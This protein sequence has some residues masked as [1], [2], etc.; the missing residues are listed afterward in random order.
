ATPPNRVVTDIKVDPANHSRV[1]VSFGGYNLNSL[2]MTED[3]GATWQTVSGTG[4]SAL[5]AIQINTIELHPAR[6]NWVYVGTDLG[7]LASEDRGATWSRTPRYPGT[8]NGNEG[9]VNTEIADLFWAGDRLIAA[10]HGRGMY[11]TRPLAYIYV[12][13]SNP[14]AGSGSYTDPFQ[15]FALAY[16]RAGNGSTIYVR[17]GTYDLTSLTMTKRVNI[18]KDA[19]GGTGP[20]V[21]E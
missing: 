18:F 2:W 20:A 13:D 1:Y 6:T 16:S 19:A 12:D 14:L 7:M 5:P 15:S 4:A 17:S 3:A 10:T 21:I 8:I 9:P 11:W